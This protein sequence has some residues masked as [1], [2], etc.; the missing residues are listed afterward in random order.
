MR[1][2]AARPAPISAGPVSTSSARCPLRSTCAIERSV[3]GAT[4]VRAGAG[5]AA[6]TSPPSLQAVSAGR[7]SVAICPG[8]VFAA[9][10]AAAPSAPTL[11]DD[12]VVRTQCADARARPSASAVSG[13]S[14]CRWYVAWSPTMFTIGDDAR[15]ALW[16]FAMPFA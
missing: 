6:P 11:A 9:C 13:V 2:A 5:N 4:G 14:Y 16:M 8:G 12:A 15:R 7:I 10:A 3:S 1:C